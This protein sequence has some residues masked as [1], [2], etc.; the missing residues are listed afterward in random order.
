MNRRFAVA[1][2]AGSLTLLPVGFLLYGD[3]FAFLFEEGALTLPG[4]MRQSPSIG[5]IV[6]GQVGFGTLVALAISW[7]GKKDLVGGAATGAILG[8]LMAVGYDFAQYGTSN[9]WTLGATLADPFV[10]ALLVGSSG[11]VTGWVLGGE[12]VSAVDTT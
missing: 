1:V 4:V 11:A 3:V 7:R 12:S 2:L 8:F 10:T 9:L 5:W 6:A